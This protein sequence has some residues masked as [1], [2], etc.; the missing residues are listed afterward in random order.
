MVP[1][2]MDVLVGRD[3]LGIGRP[4]PAAPDGLERQLARQ[5]KAGDGLL[6]RPAVDAGIDQRRQRHVA[7]NAAEA[8]EIAESHA[9]TPCH[10]R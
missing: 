5:A 3:D 10:E 1:V 2:A 7:G 8:V 6:D 9:L 4:E